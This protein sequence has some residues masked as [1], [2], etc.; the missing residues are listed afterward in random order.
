MRPEGVRGTGLRGKDMFRFLKEVRQNVTK[1]IRRKTIMDKKN[2]ELQTA[3]PI[4]CLIKQDFSTEMVEL[5]EK[6]LRQI[7]G[8]GIEALAGCAACR[9]PCSNSSSFSSSSSDIGPITFFP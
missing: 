7:V 8:G 5:S 6:D 1:P 4:N 2:I 3:Q 9:T